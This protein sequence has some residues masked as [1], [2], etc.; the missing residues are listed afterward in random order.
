MG[1]VN[2]DSALGDLEQALARLSRLLPPEGL[3]RDRLD[4]CWRAWWDVAVHQLD[5][6]AELIER[7]AD[8]YFSQPEADEDGGAP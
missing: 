5:I 1:L 2:H 3:L 6:E 8:E 4:E 7:R